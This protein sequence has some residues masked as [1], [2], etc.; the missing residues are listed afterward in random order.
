MREYLLGMI[1]FQIP[2]HM[3]CFADKKEHP[4]FNTSPSDYE[5]GDMSPAACINACGKRLHGFAGIRNGELCMCSSE[6]PE[7]FV[8]ES[9]CAS[10]CTGLDDSTI[11]Q[12]CGGNSYYSVYTTSKRI[13]G[14]DIENVSEK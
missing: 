11:Q 2:E 7:S 14:F 3:G 9:L 10:Q 13:N 6:K 1:F 5:P 4:L 12:K 8:D